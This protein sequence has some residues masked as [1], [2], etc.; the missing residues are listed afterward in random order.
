MRVYYWKILPDGRLHEI[1]DGKTND[2]VRCKRK[3]YGPEAIEPLAAPLAHFGRATS[4][5]RRSHSRQAVPQT[6]DPLHDGAR[7]H[8]A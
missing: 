4:A 2:Y 7:L 8:R 1:I 6:V 3:D 5:L